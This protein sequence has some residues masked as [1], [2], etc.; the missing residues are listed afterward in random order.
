MSRIWMAVVGAAVLPRHWRGP[1]FALLFWRPW[2][3]IVIGLLTAAVVI[4]L[5]GASAAVVSTFQLYGCLALAAAMTSGSVSRDVGSDRRLILFQ[6]PGSIVQ[7]YL[8]LWLLAFACTAI[9]I[10]AVWTMGRPFSGHDGP[11]N[12]PV[13]VGALLFATMV[14][15]A[16]T[17]ATTLVRSGETVLVVAWAVAPVLVTVIGARYALSSPVQTLIEFPFIPF[18]AVFQLQQALASENWAMWKWYWGPQLVLFPI[19]CLGSAAWRLKRIVANG[20]T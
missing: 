17:L 15:A 18:N 4:A 9:A 12:V 5:S 6:R 7:H 10:V 8:R 20:L 3:A 16:G 19:I 14:F 2:P 13:L 1:V 11:L